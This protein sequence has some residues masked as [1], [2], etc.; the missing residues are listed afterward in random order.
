MCDSKGV[1]RKDRTDI[2]EQK[3]RFATDRDLHTLDE[4]IEGAD[5]FLG[6]S[7]ANV[8]TPAML[9][10]MAPKPVV[11]ALANPNPEIEYELALAT[12][13]D[14]IMATG[15]SDYANQVNNV[16]GFPYIFRGALDCR[17]TAINEEMKIAATYAIADL[18]RQPVPESVLKLYGL[19][20]LELG[21]DYILPKP[22][23]P[24][25][26]TAVAPAVARGAMQSG[27]AQS[28]ITDWSAYND[29]L[30]ALPRS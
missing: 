24:R 12:R 8:L 3:R 28:P 4:A 2:D 30:N 22:F 11:F 1:I 7:V 6:L 18:T 20:K 29:F 13:D 10:K 9:L 21:K 25:M 17:A 27:V 23:D 26:L 16:L 5:V 14:V 19:E 15:R